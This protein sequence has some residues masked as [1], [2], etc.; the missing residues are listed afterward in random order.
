MHRAPRSP[1]ASPAA[2]RGRPSPRAS[3]PRHRLGHGPRR[4]RSRPARPRSRDRPGPDPASSTELRGRSPGRIAQ[5]WRRDRS[6]QPGARARRAAARGVPATD[7]HL[8]DRGRA[9]LARAFSARPGSPLAPRD[10]LLTLQPTTLAHLIAVHPGRSRPRGGGSPG[11]RLSRRRVTSQNWYYV[12]SH[13][14]WFS[15]RG[16]GWR[17]RGPVWDRLICRVL[18]LAA[19]ADRSPVALWVPRRVCAWCSR[20]RPAQ[21]DHPGDG[22]TWAWTRSTHLRFTGAG[23]DHRKERRGDSTPW[24]SA[25]RRRSERLPHLRPA[26][27]ALR[28]RYHAVRWRMH[29]AR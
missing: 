16:T 28:R 22:G 12:N 2:H 9:V 18:R 19:L 26:A 13:R 5:R 14:V 11:N 1:R 25:D 10:F 21:R 6:G 8:A 27:P 4:P 20:P 29:R 17:G 15:Y 7:R 3:H 24:L 23:A